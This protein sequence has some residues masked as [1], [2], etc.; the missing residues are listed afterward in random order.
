MV[1]PRKPLR[2]Q[3]VRLIN[4]SHQRMANLLVWR[5]SCWSHEI[6]RFRSK[7]LDLERDLGGVEDTAFLV[8]DEAGDQAGYERV[9]ASFRHLMETLRQWQ[10]SDA[11]PSRSKARD[12]MFTLWKPWE[13]EIAR[14]DQGWEK[15]ER[16]RDHCESARQDGRR[17]GMEALDCLV[18]PDYG[19][20]IEIWVEG[21][22]EGDRLRKAAGTAPA[23]V[24]PTP[25]SEGICRSK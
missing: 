14:L 7:L 25:G 19:D 24:P 1:S 9:R 16:W 21:W 18:N 10:I 8:D 22:R 15:V 11:D 3:A 13:D 4:L 5:P 23:A 17:A 6:T 2:E 20:V 12:E